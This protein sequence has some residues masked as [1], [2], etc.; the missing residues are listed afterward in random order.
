M[1]KICA[2][3]QKNTTVLSLDLSHNLITDAGVLHLC[4]ALQEGAAPDLI[5]LKMHDNIGVNDVGLEALKDLQS[6]RKTIRVEM[7][8]Q[9]VEVPATA[10]DR[11]SIG[12]QG[13]EDAQESRDS[14]KVDKLQQS[15]LVQ[16]LFQVGGPEFGKEAEDVDDGGL[17]NENYMEMSEQNVEP[18]EL[19]KLL[20]NEVRTVSLF[21][22]LCMRRA[23]VLP[24]VCIGNSS[25]RC[26][27]VGQS[28]AR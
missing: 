1:K 14:S 28:T 23:T 25:A 16:R 3:L 27:G 6:V 7:Q 22:G 20:W 9:V 11:H 17:Q 19:S 10:G 26:G 2:A 13:S 4:K 15:S 24:I 8:A 12:N 18:E 21:Q 5:E